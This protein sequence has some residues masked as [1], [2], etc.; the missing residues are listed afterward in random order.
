M[1]SASTGTVRYN[2]P[3]NGQDIRAGAYGNLAFSDFA[4]TLPASGTITVRIIQ[5]V[6][7]G[8]RPVDYELQQNSPNPFNPSTTIRYAI[9]E[10]SIVQLVV[11]NGLGQ[12]VAVLA[13]GEE[14]AG[15]HD[16]TFGASGMASG[17]YFYRL[18]A[19][20]FVQTRKLILMK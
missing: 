16:V 18:R 6:H 4:K 12:Q 20:S 2:Q 1:T 19:G 3:S 14:E 15:F 9:P 11:Y 10:K 8:T 17:A 13:Q 5:A 7:E